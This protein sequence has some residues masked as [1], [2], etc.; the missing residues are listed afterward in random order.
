MSNSVV[1][2][3]SLRIDRRGNIHMIA[4]RH[5]FEVLRSKVG[6][7]LGS[8]LRIGQF[9]FVEVSRNHYTAIP[10]VRSEQLEREAKQVAN[11]V[12]QCY[13][14]LILFEKVFSVQGSYESFV[15]F[16]QRSPSLEDL[17]RLAQRD[18]VH[19]PFLPLP[20]KAGAAIN[21]KP[22]TAIV[23][24]NV[25]VSPAK[26]ATVSTHTVAVS[27]TAKRMVTVNKVASDTQL[28]A[29]ASKFGRNS[30]RV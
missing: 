21:A 29:L 9:D 24:K 1:Q 18:G 28:A 17:K 27:N 8:S 23:T 26:V 13:R 25:V 19:V 15:I 20:F 2:L 11:T 5:F 30:Q 6:A 10:D 14:A 12:L 16:N 3:S 7:P 4:T 22:H